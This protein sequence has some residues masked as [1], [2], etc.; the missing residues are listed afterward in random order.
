MAHWGP[1]SSLAILP[2]LL[3]NLMFQ[4]GRLCGN[5]YYH[6]QITG[7][8]WRE[9]VNTL[10]LHLTNRTLVNKFRVFWFYRRRKHQILRGSKQLAVL[11]MQ[12]FT[13]VSQD[14]P[15]QHS[16]GKGLLFY[17]KRFSKSS[18]FEKTTHFASFTKAYTNLFVHLNI[19]ML[20]ACQRYCRCR[21]V[22]A[23]EN[24]TDKILHS[25]SSH[26][27]RES[28]STYKNLK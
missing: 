18:M 11:S 9:G 12:Y 1:R 16:V 27:S 23:S 3:Y 14:I 8:K 17:A 2:S 20:T 6:I 28:S 10:E 21:Q 22:D 25:W 15:Y 7:R 13:L 4:K 19:C 24:N 26:P 5:H